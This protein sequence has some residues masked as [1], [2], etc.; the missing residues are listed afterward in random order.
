M[1]RTLQRIRYIWHRVGVALLILMPLAAY[2]TFRPWGVPPEVLASRDGVTVTDDS[3]AIAFMPRQ[4]R[5]NALMLLPGCPV[6]PVAYAPLARRVADN[7]VL[8]VIVR[9][10]FRC[11]PGTMESQLDARV[12]RLTQRWPEMR[13]V[14]AGHSRGAAHT[15]R[16]AAGQPAHIA[17]YVLMGTSHPRDRD[18]SRLPLEITKIAATRDGVAGD[19]QFDTTRLPPSTRWVRIEGGNHSQFAYYGFQL[20][21]GRATVSR[22][23]QQDAV[24][25][26]L[27]EALPVR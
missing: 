24:L 25:R 22:E 20:F 12:Y 11:A 18:L 15:V 8:A 23:A 1:R 13:W 17:A 27:L 10:P 16:I 6:D 5:A 7:G 2:L 21:D 26:A 19:G 9:V 14:L 3:D 4:A